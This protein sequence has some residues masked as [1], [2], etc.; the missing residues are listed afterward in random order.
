MR[1]LTDMPDSDIGADREEFSS[2]LGIVL[3]MARKA[4]G[5]TQEEAAAKL[6]MSAAAIGRWE[7]GANKV[8]GY[9]LVRL[10]RLYKFDPDLAVNP[11]ASRVEI[12][13][14]LEPV[15]ERARRAVRNAVLRPLPPTD[16]GE[17][18]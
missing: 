15:G 1:S 7:A 12:R 18:G 4:A 16:A 5:I 11:P 3:A 9:D 17:P 14:R 6:E 8:S 10:I 13:K 2:R